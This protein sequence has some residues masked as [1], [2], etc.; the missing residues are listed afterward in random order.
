MESHLTILAYG[1]ALI[2]VALAEEAGRA[3][4]EQRA[5]SFTIGLNGSVAD[6]TAF[7]GPV[8]EAEWAPGWSRR[9]IHP[10]QALQPE[11]QCLL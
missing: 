6:V 10:A 3:V 1:D 11:G 5:Q 7:F 9:F 4:V 8:H 2:Q